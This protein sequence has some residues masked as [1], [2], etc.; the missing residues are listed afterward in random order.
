[1]YSILEP[2][3]DSDEPRVLFIF[4]DRYYKEYMGK[5]LKFVFKGYDILVARLN[6]VDDFDSFDPLLVYHIDGY[7][8]INTM[9]YTNDSSEFRYRSIFIQT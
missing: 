1:M 5:T 6:F 2:I 8:D 7:S 9:K 3:V 4:P